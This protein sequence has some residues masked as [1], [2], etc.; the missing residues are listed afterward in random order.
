V[1]FFFTTVSPALA[2]TAR[3]LGT[4]LKPQLELLHEIPLGNVSADKIPDVTGK[5]WGSGIP[6]TEQVVSPDG[7]HILVIEAYKM[8]LY[9]VGSGKKVWQ[10]MTYGGVDNHEVVNDR[11]S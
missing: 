7:K 8:V 1:T 6:F 3:A 11:Y 10:K 4:S 5:S 9:S 2:A